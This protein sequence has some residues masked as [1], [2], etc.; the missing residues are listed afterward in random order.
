M[1]I[2]PSDL[3]QVVVKSLDVTR[4]TAA[5]Q[6]GVVASQQTLAEQLKR[7]ALERT[8]TV[9]QFDED[10]GAAAVHE[11]DSRR[12]QHQEQESQARRQKPAI[13]DET[14]QEAAA[15]A[16]VAQPRVGRHVDLQ[17]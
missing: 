7:K 8:E 11:R 9:Q 16:T 1:A 14:K 2:R 6:Q 10:A 4:D 12:Q 17:A 13:P 5:Q 3:Q 15:K